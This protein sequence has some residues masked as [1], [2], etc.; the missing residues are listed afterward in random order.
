MRCAAAFLLVVALGAQTPKPE[1]R[2]SIRGVVKDTA[3]APVADVTVQAFP[4]DRSPHFFPDPESGGVAILSAPLTTTTD[5][6]GSYTFSGLPPGTYSVSVTNGSVTRA[7]PKRVDLG[8]GKEVT[9]D[10]LVPLNPSIGGR[11]L[12]ANKEPVVDTFVWLLRAD[13]NGGALVQT[14]IGPKITGDDGV[15]T[16]DTGLEPNRRY[17][18]LAD[19]PPP[20]ELVSAAPDLKSRDAIEVPTYYPSATRMDSATPVTLQPGEQRDQ[21]DIKVATA[22]FYCIDGKIRFSG[23]LGSDSFL[24]QDAALAGSRLVRLR[25]IASSDGTYHAC[26]ISPGSY[27]LATDEASTEFAVSGGDLEHVDLSADL[28]HLRLKVEWDG[29]PPPVDHS[30]DEAANATL[31]KIASL[32][33][34]G[35]ALSDEELKRLAD[36][37]SHPGPD[38]GDLASLTSDLSK[39]DHTNGEMYA[40]LRHLF[41]NPD[42]ASLS[43]VSLNG[44]IAGAFEGP[45]F[46]GRIPSDAPIRKG[47]LAGDYLVGAQVFGQNDA[48]VKEITYENLKLTDGLLRL[49]PGASGT[50]RMLIACGT[51]TLNVN[52]VS[53]EGKPVSGA[54]VIVIPESTVT[55]AGL[56]RVLTHGSADQNG[57]YTAK[58]LPPGKYKVLATAQSITWSRPEDLEKLAL[59]L[60]QA[61]DVD[62]AS[63]ASMEVAVQPVAY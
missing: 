34:M 57:N 53:S 38:D 51:A 2:A 56:S 43:L 36:R 60:F 45:L 23:G 11:V 52:V 18:V 63:K 16:F 6:A 5:E 39:S 32:L 29:D 24:V 35:T 42:V 55:A 30:Q 15:Y 46:S 40:L 54:Y 22:A 31:R 13:Y 21:V 33:G 3:G 14:V 8:A 27:R 48:Y 37:L 17:V 25:G 47:V 58:G 49:P 4:V 1:T 10:F 28:A 9:V 44:P 50:V 20:D 62:L 26:G 41:P 59:V 61:K 19:R 7:D 12:N